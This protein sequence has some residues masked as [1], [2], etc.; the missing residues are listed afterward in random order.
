[1]GKKEIGMYIKEKSKRDLVF[2]SF[3]V[4]R[5]SNKDI[6]LLC[7]KCRNISSHCD[8]YSFAIQKHEIKEYPKK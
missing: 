5:D 6:T 2:N 1:M 8:G 3:Q 7:I 4:L